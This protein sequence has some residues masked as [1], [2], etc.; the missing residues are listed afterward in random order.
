MNFLRY[1]I[2]TL[3]S[4][5]S[6]R[7]SWQ[8]DNVKSVRKSEGY[9][10]KRYIVLHAGTS[11]GFVK[12]VD[13][14]FC[15]KSK[16]A[17]YHGEMNS[18]IFTKWVEERLIP[19]LK[20]PSLIVMDNAPYHNVS[21]EKQPSTS[22]RR[23]EL[24]EWLHKYNII[25]DEK[26]TN[27]ELLL[28]A[29]RHRQEDR[30]V[31]D[32]LLRKHGHEVLRLPPYHCEFNAIDLIWAKA[33][34]DYN[35]NIGRDE[36]LEF[37][38]EEV[39][40]KCVRHTEKVNSEWHEREKYIINCVADVEPIIIDVNDLSS[41]SS[42]LGS[43]V[44]FE[45]LLPIDII[46]GGIALTDILFSVDL[47]IEKILHNVGGFSVLD[48]SSFSYCSFD[49]AGNILDTAM[50]AIFATSAGVS[51]SLLLSIT[52]K[53]KYKLDFLRSPYLSGAVGNGLVKIFREKSFV[54]TIY[55]QKTLGGLSS[56]RR[57]TRRKNSEYEGSDKVV[58]TFLIIGITAVSSI[59]DLIGIG[60]DTTENKR[61]V[62]CRP[63][64][65]RP[66]VRRKKKG[67]EIIFKNFKQLLKAEK[68]YYYFMSDSEE[69]LELTN[70]LNNLLTLSE[71][72]NTTVQSK[73]NMALPQISVKDYMELIP[74]FDGDPTILSSFI[75]AC[76]NVLTLM[77][78]NNDAIRISFTLMHIRTKI[79]GKAA[80]VLA[81]RTYQTFPELKTILISIFGD[82]RNEESLLSDLNLLRQKPNET[83]FQ[84]ADRCIDLRCLLLS[85]VECSDLERDQKNIKIEMYNKTALRAYLTGL[86]PNMS[87][88]LR[89][90]SPA[91]LEQAIQY[92][93]EEENIDYHRSLIK[94]NN[95]QSSHS[96]SNQTKIQIK[97]PNTRTYPMHL[98]TNTQTNNVANSTN[99]LRP[100]PQQ[101]TSFKPVWPNTFQNQHQ[102]SHV[103]RPMHN[104]FAPQN[105][106]KPN[107]KP[108]PMEVS[109]GTMRTFK[110]PSNHFK[111]NQPQRKY[112]V[113]ELHAQDQSEIPNCYSSQENLY[114]TDNEYV[115]YAE[116]TEYFEDRENI[117]DDEKFH[118]PASE[119]NPQN[120]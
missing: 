51:L 100:F 112:T 110:P 85:K 50:F 66:E 71:N 22:S 11:K 108:V 43:D 60:P 68:T 1:F 80:S 12:D 31:I 29:K 53:E 74:R 104:A 115:A 54:S 78:P 93:A 94:S 16:V 89:C 37:C 62:Y 69:I 9:D 24:I 113:E 28:L 15:S 81:A 90:K 86:N 87:H 57:R 70:R 72:E 91:T 96:H 34:G 27:A 5:G 95:P 63:D 103:H 88:L 20:E 107:F 40:Y 17:D 4:K 58:N 42:S 56:L 59:E 14:L 116:D 3:Y 97:K 106:P 19:N 23:M 65:N 36:A 39:W 38:N 41:K 120:K 109:S 73:F 2:I 84:F 25:Y 33:K 61:T 67:Q 48:F 98:P 26:M 13:L 105:A 7:M 79:V 46:E 77:A 45:Q 117:N 8:D 55:H 82:Q 52:T 119:V 32:D 10:G 83:S 102:K 35:D 92:T 101:N 47:S 64:R 75:S 114:F 76:E 118:I 21:I 30:Y 44:K 18:N 6:K 111:T 49:L 99:T